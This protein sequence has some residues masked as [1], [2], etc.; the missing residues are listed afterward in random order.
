MSDGAGPAQRVVV[1]V[2]HG[3]WTEVERL[4]WIDL[5]QGLAITNIRRAVQAKLELIGNAT[6]FETVVVSVYRH[7]TDIVDDPVFPLEDGKFAH[8]GILEEGENVIVVT[9]RDRAGNTVT[10]RVTVT[11]DSIPP[12][13]QITFPEDGLVTNQGEVQLQAD[14]GLDSDVYLNG[15]RIPNHGYVNTT[16]WLDEGPNVIELRAID[17]MGNVGISTVNV[18]LDTVAPEV[19]VTVPGVA[20]VRTNAP[21]I[22]IA[23]HTEGD[24]V[25]VTVHGTPV[26]L[27]DGAFEVVLTLAGDGVHTVVVEARDLA[28]NTDRF[29]LTVDLLRALPPI[30]LTFDPPDDPIRDEAGVITLHGTTSDVSH[31]V[32]I[33]HSTA[34]G[35]TTTTLLLDGNTTFTVVLDLVR[36][37]NTLVVTVVDIYGNSNTTRPY[38]VE[39]SPRGDEPGPFLTTTGLLAIPMIIAIIVLSAWIMSMRK[40]QQARAK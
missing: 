2:M 26:E 13:V 7:S 8:V 35:E 20:F 28:G 37:D 21:D 30:L 17:I 19:I 9:A 5:G 4:S 40:R 11:L 25:S 18:T 34:D 36:G 3:G 23:G 6:E 15:K 27:L 22:R 33:V 39:Y 32:R 24:A 12:H 38:T 31:E 14:V 1:G 10:R 16:V 29:I